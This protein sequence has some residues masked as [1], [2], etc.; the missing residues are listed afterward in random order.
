[1][2]I[3]NL[4]I[5]SWQIGE[6]SRRER[7]ISMR[8]Q[9]VFVDFWKHCGIGDKSA[10]TQRR[11]FSG[12]WSFSGYLV[13][14]SVYGDDAELKMSA[15]ELLAK[16]L[17]VDEGPLVFMDNELWQNELDAVCRKF[18][19]NACL[20][21]V[22]SIIRPASLFLAGDNAAKKPYSSM[23]YLRQPQIAATTESGFANNFSIRPSG[24]RE[25]RH[26]HFR[27][28]TAKR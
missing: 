11:Y 1:M 18:C 15:D 28:A 3:S 6:A 20:I 13:K 17:S 2:N 14:K 26:E 12:L 24:F 23:V 9:T 4:D 19:I 21:T 22:E 7:K 27:P 25:R 8:L 10:K 5:E 16:Y